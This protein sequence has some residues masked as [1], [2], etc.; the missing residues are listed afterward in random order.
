M[1][2]S[3]FLFFLALAATAQ[4]TNRFAFPALAG[5]RLREA[6]VTSGTND[7]GN[8][9]VY[10]VADNYY[11]QD[12]YWTNRA[13]P[14]GD[15]WDHW[16]VPQ[17]LAAKAAGANCVRLTWSA[18]AFVGNSAHHGAAAW[19]GTNTYSGLTNEIGMVASLCQSNGMWLYPSC[20][21]SRVINDG[22]LS[23]NLVF[24]YLSNFC[25]AAVLYPNVP[26]IDVVQEADGTV[27]GT[28]GFVAV[29]CPLWLKA[30]RDGMN[31]S[32]RKVPVTCSLNG[33]SN[34]GDLNLGKRWQAYNLA[35]GGADYFDCHAYYQYTVQDFYQAVTNRWGL[36]VIFGETGIN[37]SGVWGNGPENESTHPYSSELRQD[38]FFAAQAVAEQPYYQL[39]GLW[40]IAPN[41]LTSA[42]DFGMYSGVQNGAYQFTQGRD[43]LRNFAMFPTNVQPANYSWSV[44][45][46]GV[47]TSAANYAGATRYAVQSG[48]FD[49]SSGDGLRASMWQR[50]N[51]MVQAMGN[52]VAPIYVDGV[53]KLWQSALPNALGQ[54][55]QFEI[56]PQT[57]VCYLDEYATWECVA[58]GQVNGSVYLVSLTHDLAGI[59]DNRLEIFSFNGATQ[60]KTS[61]A[62]ITYG[63]ALD[64]TQWWGLTVSVSTDV[65]PTIIT[66][67]VSNLTAGVALTPSL[68]CTD[69]TSFLQVPG[70]MG[71]C[72]YS[73]QTYYSNILFTATFDNAPAV[74]P[75]PAVSQSGVS[76]LLSWEAA[77]GGSGTINYLPQFKVSDA[78][79]FPSTADWTN[80]IETTNTTETLNSLPEGTNLI[81]RVMS[82]DSAGETN[83]SPWQVVTT[84]SKSTN[85][86]DLKLT[87]SEGGNAGS[88]A[89]LLGVQISPS[90]NGH[91]ES[92]TN[93][94]DWQP[95]TNF[96][97]S[98]TN[99]LF[100]NAVTTNTGRFFFRA[101]VP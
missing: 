10:G 18:D 27:A 80:G 24:Q 96:N 98:V 94:I 85:N 93:L 41:W 16:I 51:N 2:A 50:Q 37:M 19:V 8:S 70:G 29:D 47:N 32:G 74:A 39:T 72:G 9:P 17:V 75:A 87:L 54:S 25:A 99:V 101:V 68:V 89:L 43:Q 40:A 88:K 86:V 31:R 12:Y 49:S 52:T 53:A 13:G 65:N 28:N 57:P 20:T 22:N 100:L 67:T 63:T 55:I 42:E 34:A 95:L 33:A 5:L 97:G 84:G 79:G 7:S 83:Y 35:A 44:C 82:V 6:N 90:A 1:L 62:K 73:G 66:C 4:V 64:L 45:C 14:S 58:R 46:T 15:E 60:K 81:F 69:S 59:L 23:T 30:A 76:A 91:I 78:F 38:F 3:I 36:P 48:M 56:P 77:V 61:L 26:A 11:D 71:L 21:D 92:S